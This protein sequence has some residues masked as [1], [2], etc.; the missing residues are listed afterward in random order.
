MSKVKSEETGSRASALIPV[1]VNFTTDGI[2]GM[3][4]GQGFTISN[5]FLPYTY[6]E[7]KEVSMDLQKVGFVI[8][9]VQN[10]FESN[11]WNTSIRANMIFLKDADDFKS[12]VAYQYSKTNEFK[13]KA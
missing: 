11:Q 6:N 9:G 7:R 5:K 13:N 10:S 8:L 4:I 12:S 2:S 3:N 1:S